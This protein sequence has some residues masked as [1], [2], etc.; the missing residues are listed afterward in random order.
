LNIYY[1]KKLS[2]SGLSAKIFQHEGPPPQWVL[3]IDGSLHSSVDVDD[4]SRLYFNYT[5]KLGSII[6]TLF[7]EKEKLSTLH[8]G[9]GALSVARYIEATRPGSPQVVVEIETDLLDFVESA[10][11]LANKADIEF[12]TGDAREVVENNKDRFTNK[13][14][15][16]V[17]EIFLKRTT[18]A[19]VT[20]SEFYTLL[21][22]TLKPGG[23]VIVNVIDGETYQ[24]ASN[25]FATLKSVFGEVKAVIDEEEYEEKI[26]TNILMVTSKNKDLALL[27]DYSTLE[28]R[29]AVIIQG[30][31]AAEWEAIGQVI[32]DETSADWETETKWV[33]KDNEF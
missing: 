3:V 24:Y 15:L 4:P 6:E 8:L 30:E 5:Q 19:H 20:S 31:L 11:P 23:V 9:A 12:L 16:I 10:I 7:P 29:P 13:F 2:Y 32:Y 1:E 25:Q 27:S 26:F 28:P 21:S 33:I 14:D 22:D 17:V 18:P